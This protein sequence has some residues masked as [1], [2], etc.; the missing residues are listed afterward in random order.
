MTESWDVIV[1]GS[2]MGGMVT[3]AAVSRL[4]HKVLMLEQ[5][6]SPGGQ[7]HSFSRE[8]FSWDVGLH[9]LGGFGP[10]ESERAVLDWLCDSPIELAPVGAVYDT[11]HI[12]DSAPLQLSRPLAAQRMDL[13][14][15]FPGESDA[16]DTWFD[17]IADGKDA[18]SVLGQVRSFP[19]AFESA[20]WWWRGRRFRRYCERTTAEV[21]NAITGNADLARVLVAQWGDFGGRP[22]SASFAI[23]AA[24][25]W[26]YLEAG[27]YY[28]VGGASSIATHLL[29][30]ITTSGGEVCSGVEVSSLILESGTVTGV[31]TADGE[32]YFGKHIVSNIGARETVDRLLPD[33]HGHDDWV[34]EIRAIGSNI[35]HFSLFLG[36]SGD[37][38]AAGMTRSNHWLYPT[39]NVDAVWADAPDGKPPAMF[40]SFASLKDPAH[41]PGVEMKYAGE[42]IAWSDWC[43]VEKWANVSRDE[44]GE[45]YE[46]FKKA[47]ES[48]LLE[49]FAHY[50]PRLAELI[51]FH[52]VSTPLATA[53]ITG[54]RHGAFYGLD[55]TPQ[56]I[57]SHALRMKTPLDGLYLT[58]QDVLSPGIPGA[59]WGGILSAASIDPKVFM[60]MKAG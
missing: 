13:K 47:I 12:G 25:T 17:T 23:H 30:T 5:Y 45:E 18:L 1:I 52:E 50:F 3:A 48:T 43:T 15:R 39:G 4:G 46:L 19:P 16:I 55:V 35:C 6:A 36:F 21:A 40:V 49:Q 59:F 20:L 11:L 26:S 31:E 22:S 51:V 10:D 34:N 38:E 29:P 33:G 27:A 14:E 8:G 24:V 54:H 7:T 2:G 9:Y 60:R 32:Q 57:M 41:D 28:P 37:V 42:L 58:G 44:R 53:S 56:R